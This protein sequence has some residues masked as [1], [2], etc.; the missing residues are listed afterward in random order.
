[1]NSAARVDLIGARLSSGDEACVRKPAQ[2]SPIGCERDRR[3]DVEVIGLSGMENL[4]IQTSRELHAG[5]RPRPRSG[6]RDLRPQPRGMLTLTTSPIS[7]AL[8]RAVS[9]PMGNNPIKE[10]WGQ[11][12]ALL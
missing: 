6:C 7:D 5:G 2:A 12:S 1:M 8:R 9:S 10:E 11:S 3:V 4:A